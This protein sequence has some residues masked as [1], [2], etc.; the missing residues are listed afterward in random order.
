[1]PPCSW[2]VPPCC[3]E[4]GYGPDA[5]AVSAN[6]TLNQPA[7]GNI[8]QQNQSKYFVTNTRQHTSQSPRHPGEDVILASDLG[9]E[10]KT[11]MLS[12]VHSEM[13]SIS[14][15]SSSIAVSW[16]SK[17]SN[18]SDKE[19][20]VKFCSQFFS[21]Q[22]NIRSTRRLGS[23]DNDR[24][25]PLLVT[26]DNDVDSDHLIKNV[27]FLR[28]VDDA[29]VRDKIFVNRHMTPAESKAAFEARQLRRNSVPATSSVCANPIH[30]RVTETF[31]TTADVIPEP[32]SV[33][34]LSQKNSTNSTIAS[35]KPHPTISGLPDATNL[36]TSTTSG[37]S[38]NNG[39]D[40]SS[41]RP[42][43]L[44][45]DTSIH[46][47]L[48]LNAR[49][50]K[51]K[52][53]NFHHQMSLGQYSFVFVTESWLTDHVT[54]AMIDPLHH[55]HILRR[56]RTSKT[57]GGVCALI[58]QVFKIVEHDFNDDEKSLMVHCECEILCFDV[59]LPNAR[60]RF[61]LAYRPPPTS[62]KKE[63]LIAKTQSFL[64]LLSKLVDSRVTIHS[65]LVTWIS[66]KYIGRVCQVSLMESTMLYLIIFVRMVS[67][68]LLQNQPGWKI[69]CLIIVR[70]LKEIYWMLF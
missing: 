31:T 59:L 1:M 25:Q 70:I 20:F 6:L 34:S 10:F 43:W 2:P 11:A 37:A 21:F 46:P 38:V 36:D 48:L 14:K 42:M 35:T 54:N 64:S 26:F 51:N 57:G 24:T 9:K 19:L 15:R 30:Y 61:I 29:Y 28:T 45:V 22:P 23:G 41:G 32:V 13:K 44:T 16:I 58:S 12:A 7:S 68:N 55:Y 49:S 50:I 63:L 65:S 53:S 60:Q 69:M 3:F 40:P 52:L 39:A 47:A 56:D 18:I 5:Q 67:L 17:L 4:A 62:T 33:G 27:K 8:I 66:R